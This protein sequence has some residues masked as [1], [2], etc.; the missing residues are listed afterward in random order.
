VR[1]LA[2][3]RVE[4]VFEGPEDGVRAMVEWCRQGP[5]GAD[6]SDVEV[7]WEACEGDAGPFR[8]R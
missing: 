7:S 8:V 1:N 2:D 5:R 6:V 3:G 4:A